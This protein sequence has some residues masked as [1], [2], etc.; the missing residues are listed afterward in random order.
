[1]ELT[2]EKIM[3]AND[4]EPVEINVQ[5]WGGSVYVRALSA[6]ERLDF[7][8]TA[9]KLGEKDSGS[10]RIMALYLCRVL[11][12]KD[13]GRLFADSDADLLLDKKAAIVLD[14]FQRASAHNSLTEADIEDFEK[15]L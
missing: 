1:M 13:G 8:T 3:S 12:D 9:E 5:A 2:R 14:L 15:N 6:K 10:L 4:L 11:A 7:E